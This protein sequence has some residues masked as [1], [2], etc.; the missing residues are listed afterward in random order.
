MAH[1]EGLVD[2]WEL[3]AVCNYD[4]DPTEIKGFCDTRQIFVAELITSAS[5]RCPW[6]SVGYVGQMGRVGIVG[7]N[8]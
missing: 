1:N 8:F 5:A 4:S 2:V 3:G 7:G 6:F